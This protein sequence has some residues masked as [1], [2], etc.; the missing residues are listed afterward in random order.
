MNIKWSI[1][2][3]L[4]RGGDMFQELKKLIIDLGYIQAIWD[5]EAKKKQDESEKMYATGVSDG[6]KHAAVALDSII[7]KYST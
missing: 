7:R 3:D 4:K 1:F 6:F 5:T 2:G